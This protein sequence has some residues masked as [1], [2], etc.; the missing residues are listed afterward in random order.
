[1]GSGREIKAKNVTISIRSVFAFVASPYFALPRF[2]SFCA[3]SFAVLF[4]DFCMFSIPA[5][6]VEDSLANV[7]ATEDLGVE[8]ERSRTTSCE[9]DFSEPYS[10]EFSRSATRRTSFVKNAFTIVRTSP[11]LSRI[12]RDLWDQCPNWQEWWRFMGILSASIRHSD[13]FQA[14]KDQQLGVPTS[15]E[16]L[17]G[18]PPKETKTE[19]CVEST[20]SIEMT[21]LS[22]KK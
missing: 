19:T 9:Y 3:L 4:C 21:D 13:F 7:S 1:M 10:D 5:H 22:A 12:V 2:V 14:N 20:L 11:P 6:G 18:T 17:L 15:T 8:G 16:Q